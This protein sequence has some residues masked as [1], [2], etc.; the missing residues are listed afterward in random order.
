[1][2]SIILPRWEEP[3]VVELTKE[4]LQNELHVLPDSEL[5]V[6]DSWVQG[7]QKSTCDFVCLVEPDCL[8]SSGYF[9]SNLGLFKKNS[10]FRKLA[11]V[12]SA[13]GLNNWGNKIYGYHMEE[14]TYGKEGDIQTTSWEIQ[15]FREKRSSNLFPVQIGFLPGAIIRKSAMTAI[16]KKFE[17]L[18]ATDL[19]KLS[20]DI[21]MYLWGTGRRVHVNPNST[22]V[23]TDRNI[24]APKIFKWKA[25][26]QA[27]A[28][29]A[30]EII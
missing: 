23:S 26:S 12:S 3:T 6:A 17:K 27:K 5:I 21:S 28:L 18:D 25:N 20:T 4:N 10:Q 1:M 13:V 2:L 7:I 29:F 8:V 15:P 16:L 22:Y 9:S 30:Q 19:V 14:V 24:Q 11:M